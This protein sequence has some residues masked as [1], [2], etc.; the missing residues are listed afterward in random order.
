MSISNPVNW[1]DALFGYVMGDAEQDLSYSDVDSAFFA[2][3]GV[4][5][6]PSFDW[7]DDAMTMPGWDDIV[8]Y[9]LH[10]GTFAASASRN[11]S[12]RAVPIEVSVRHVLRA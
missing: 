3:K 11:S 9:E 4:V 10:V 12:T 8:I 2:P 1:D 6:D 5:I 7:G